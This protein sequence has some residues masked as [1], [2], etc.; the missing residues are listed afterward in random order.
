MLSNCDKLRLLCWNIDNF[1]IYNARIVKIVSV[2]N[3][4]PDSV[5]FATHNVDL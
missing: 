1:V 3:L 5:Y 2:E 4:F